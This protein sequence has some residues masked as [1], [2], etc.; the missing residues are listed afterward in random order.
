MVI[1]V[2]DLNI[3]AVRM[4]PHDEL[5]VVHWDFAGPNRP[6]WELAYVLNQWA[7]NATASPGTAAALVSG[8]RE[9]SGTIPRLD[10]S[11]F[12]LTITGFLNWT[13][14]R[15]NSALQ[16]TDLEEQAFDR[17]ALRQLIA[18]PL[19][20][21]KIEQLLDNLRPSLS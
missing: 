11:S 5:V 3:N 19:T 13:F 12:W 17:S 8:Y 15:A 6:E 7:T 16:T 9:G 10:L 14:G 1:C 21:T 20:V 2:Q 4:G 18:D